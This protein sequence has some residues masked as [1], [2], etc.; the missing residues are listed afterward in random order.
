MLNS[1]GTHL[2]TQ[3]ALAEAETGRQRAE[4]G[5]HVAHAAVAASKGNADT[6]RRENRELLAKYDD[7]LM[8]LV[9]Q[10][11]ADVSLCE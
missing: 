7:W 5:L 9:A 8:E 4:E 3:A 10:R 11:G 1:R 2:C 6:Y